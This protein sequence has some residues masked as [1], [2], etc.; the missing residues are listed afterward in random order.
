MSLGRQRKDHEQKTTARC[1]NNFD[2]SLTVNAK[3][4]I[5]WSISYVRQDLVIA[6]WSG[7]ESTVVCLEYRRVVEN[8]FLIETKDT[9]HQLP[10]GQIVTASYYQ[11][12]AGRFILFIYLY[13]L[14]F[15]CVTLL[16]EEL[17]CPSA[18]YFRHKRTPPPEYSDRCLAGYHVISF[19]NLLRF[20]L[21][22]FIVSWS[23]RL[24]SEESIYVKSRTSSECKVFIKNKTNMIFVTLVQYLIN[25]Y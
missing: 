14:I 20:H 17:R 7:G 2:S 19:F 3:K 10:D 8:V 15:V 21:L 13:F 6:S 1:S 23:H 12:V 25:C 22:N 11:K 24:F 9:I 18:E 4:K 16:E 5:P